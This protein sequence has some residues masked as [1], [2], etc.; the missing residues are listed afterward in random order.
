LAILP[1]GKGSLSSGSSKNQTDT[2]DEIKML[3][4]GI[5]P[6][7]SMKDFQLIG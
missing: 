3:S 7:W 5:K 6:K 4:H 2:M 1:Y